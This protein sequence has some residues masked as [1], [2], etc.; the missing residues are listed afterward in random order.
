LLVPAHIAAKYRIG[1]KNDA[2]DA[3]T[4]YEA[5]KRPTLNA[6]PFYRSRGYI[7]DEWLKWLKTP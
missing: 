4:I 2:N 1:K 7:G 5:I 3:L 6:T